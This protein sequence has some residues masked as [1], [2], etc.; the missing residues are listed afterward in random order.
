MTVDRYFSLDDIMR[1]WGHKER[2]KYEDVLT[3]LGFSLFRCLNDEH[4]VRF[5]VYQDDRSDDPIFIR[6]PPARFQ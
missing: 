3:A 4:R 5:C 6:V 2:L 1:V